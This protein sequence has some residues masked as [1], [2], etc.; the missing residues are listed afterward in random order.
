MTRFGSGGSVGI[1]TVLVIQR[2]WFCC[3][4]PEPPRESKPSL[5][6]SSARRFGLE[7]FILP[8]PAEPEPQV[9]YQQ[10][11]RHSRQRHNKVQPEPDRFYQ[12]HSITSGPGQVLAP[13]VTTK[14]VQ[15]LQNNLHKTIQNRSDSVFLH[16]HHHHHLLKENQLVRTR[17]FP[18]L[19]FPPET[20]NFKIQKFCSG[21]LERK[22]GPEPEPDL[23]DPG[24]NKFTTFTLSWFCWVLYRIFKTYFSVFLVQTLDRVRT[25]LSGT[26]WG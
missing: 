15:K 25:T 23:L 11:S 14:N 18:V 13:I 6:M 5:E 17:T 1:L 7:I 3:D 4:P 20:M 24:L 9:R 12:N 16:H 19:D 22:Y 21:D 26:F 8:S 2:T 10:S